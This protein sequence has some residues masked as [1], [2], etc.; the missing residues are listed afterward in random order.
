MGKGFFQIGRQGIETAT[1]ETGV[2]ELWCYEPAIGG[3]VVGIEVVVI[4]IAC[5]VFDL[6]RLD[7]VEID[8]FQGL[9]NLVFKN[10]P[11]YLTLF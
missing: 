6:G 5:I 4:D 11:F 10:N 8:G 3:A 2:G 9:F 1:A 7:G